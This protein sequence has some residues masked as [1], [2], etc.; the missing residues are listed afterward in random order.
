MSRGNY[1]TPPAEI[2]AVPGVKVT[3]GSHYRLDFYVGTADA[4]AATGLITVD[5]L[6]GQPARPLS[7][8]CYRP[9]GD[10]PPRP[11]WVATWSDSPLCPWDRVPGHMEIFRNVNGSTFRI[12]LVVSLEEQRRRRQLSEPRPPAGLQGPP[13][14]PS[15]PGEFGRLLLAAVDHYAKLGVLPAWALAKSAPAA[16]PARDHMRLVWSAPA[17]ATS[18]R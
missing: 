16:S 15:E 11:E 1:Y 13:A 6:P 4:L 18:S 5:M 10:R 7:K 3:S 2:R 17:S 8:A 12:A 9:T 14:G